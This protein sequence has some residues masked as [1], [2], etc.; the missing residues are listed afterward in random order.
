MTI[1]PEKDTV[2]NLTLTYQK[3]RSREEDIFQKH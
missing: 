3:E 2:G 1:L